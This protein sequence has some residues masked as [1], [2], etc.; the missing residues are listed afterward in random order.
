MKITVFLY[1]MHKEVPEQYPALLF[2]YPYA[3]RIEV[4]G[5]DK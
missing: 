4:T 3:G 1:Y 2:F 5:V